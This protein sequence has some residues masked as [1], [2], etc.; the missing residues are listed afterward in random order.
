MFLLNRLVHG[1]TCAGVLPI[2][3]MNFAKFSGI[4]NVGHG[5]IRQGNCNAQCA[6]LLHEFNVSVY[7]QLGYVSIVGCLAE[8]SMKR[9]VEE[10]QILP[11]YATKG[12]IT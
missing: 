12:K 3:Y 4:G 2:Q 9:V 10:V 5:Y 7:N 6:S 11:D 8:Q 1:F